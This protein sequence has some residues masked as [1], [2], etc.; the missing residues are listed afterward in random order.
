M[1]IRGQQIAFYFCLW[2]IGSIEKMVVFSGL[3]GF[4][5]TMYARVDQF[6]NREL[7]APCSRHGRLVREYL[8]GEQ[9]PVEANARK[10]PF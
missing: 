10:L 5:Y 4:G 8:E 3:P 6:Y 2:A 1:L 9:E 7:V